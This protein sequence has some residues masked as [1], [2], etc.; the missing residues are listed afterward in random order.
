MFKCIT[1]KSLAQTY[2]H[3]RKTLLPRVIPSELNLDVFKP[4]KRAE[5]VKNKASTFIITLCHSLSRQYY[6]T[7]VASKRAKIAHYRRSF[8]ILST[9]HTYIY[10]ADNEQAS[11]TVHWW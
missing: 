10:S 7:N 11:S 3:S 9:L 1:Y 2:Q 5:R 4:I 8:V 6:N